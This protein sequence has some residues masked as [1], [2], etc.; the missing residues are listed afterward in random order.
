[1]ALI[2]ATAHGPAQ[3]AAHPE[4]SAAQTWRGAVGAGRTSLGNLATDRSKTTHGSLFSFVSMFDIVE[5]SYF[6][7]CA[8]LASYLKQNFANM[9]C[10]LS[11]PDDSLEA[12]HSSGILALSFPKFS[13]TLKCGF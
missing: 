9:S 11:S 2:R 12:R 6:L 13:S 1:M 5:V 10:R 3:P 8:L 7:H 4:V